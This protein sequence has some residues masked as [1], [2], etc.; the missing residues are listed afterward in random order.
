MTLPGNMRK[1]LILTL[2]G[3]Q[4]PSELGQKSEIEIFLA[5]ERVI[6]YVF[7]FTFVKKFP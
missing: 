1:S 7:L 6:G 5:V 2:L 3:G 4:Q